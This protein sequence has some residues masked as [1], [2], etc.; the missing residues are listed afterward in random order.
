MQTH[1]HEH[2][3]RHSWPVAP[4]TRSAPLRII[5]LV[6]PQRLAASFKSD[7]E[8]RSRSYRV[9]SREQQQWQVPASPFTSK[10]FHPQ[11]QSTKIIKYLPHQAKRK[12]KHR[13]SPGTNGFFLWLARII[14]ASVITLRMMLLKISLRPDH[15]L[16]VGPWSSS[17]PVK[18]C[19]YR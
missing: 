4:R 14:G 15:T 17:V 5:L 7:F 16:F 3:Q 10:G 11:K 6:F 1:Q 8:A 18:T 13:A 2:T 19:Q 9:W 12:E